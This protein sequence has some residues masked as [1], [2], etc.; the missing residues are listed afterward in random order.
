MQDYHIKA[1]PLIE[2][3]APELI[4]DVP[5]AVHRGCQGVARARSSPPARRRG[6]PT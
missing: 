6:G 1:N 4:D 2:T 5:R 3:S